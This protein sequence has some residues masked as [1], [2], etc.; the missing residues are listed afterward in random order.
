MDRI[1]AKIDHGDEL[2]SSEQLKM[3]RS[4]DREKLL[5]AYIQKHPLCDEAELEILRNHTLL[6][7][8][9]KKWKLCGDAEYAL[10]MIRCGM[11]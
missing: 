4:S 9:Q 11:W 3:L 5:K 8:Y 1:I 6:E 2:T 10:R 7:I